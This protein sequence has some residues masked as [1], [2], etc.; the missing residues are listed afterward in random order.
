MKI[1]EIF[2][3]KSEENATKN[4]HEIPHAT[5]IT[6]RERSFFQ[7]GDLPDSGPLGTVRRNVTP[8]LDHISRDPLMP[9]NSS[10]T[11]CHVGRKYT[12]LSHSEAH[13]ASILGQRIEFRPG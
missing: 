8:V 13:D 4:T 7:K 10:Q 1:V 5:I 2:Q 9:L 3:S 6:P 11:Y 12:L